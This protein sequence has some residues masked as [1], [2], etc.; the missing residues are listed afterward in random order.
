MEAV[1]RAI[2][3]AGTIDE[4]G[5]LRLDQP[6]ASIGPRRVRII[7]LFPEE[8]DIDEQEWLKMAANNEVFDFLIDP[9]EDIYTL[10]DGKPF[11]G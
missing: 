9:A 8:D 3:L 10:A 4:S 7:L 11:S 1:S 6:I 2:E 5:Q